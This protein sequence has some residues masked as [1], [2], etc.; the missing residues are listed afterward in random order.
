MKIIPLL[1]ICIIL[2]IALSPLNAQV[3]DN[4]YR[5]GYLRLEIM[6]EHESFLDFKK[7]VFTVENAWYN[8]ELS[9]EVFI[10]EL[11]FYSDIGKYLLSKEAITYNYPD[12]SSVLSHASLFKL[13]TDTIAIQI[14]DTTISY[15]LPFQYNHEDYSGEKDWANMFVTTLMATRKGNCHSLPLLYKLIAEEMGEKAWLAL[16]PNHLYIKLHNEANGWYNT[17]L[18]S[19]IFPT[20]AWIKSSG[21]IHLNAIKNGIYMDTLSQKETIALCM[22]D[23]ALGYQRKYPDSYDSGFVLK[24]CDKALE[25][26]PHYMNGLLLKAEMMYRIYE[27]GQEKDPKELEGIEKL[28]AHVHQLGYRK[29]PKEMYLHWLESMGRNSEK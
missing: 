8:E 22:V 27:S 21:Y 16:A 19:G 7:A 24:C 18:T 3:I 29:M 13:M 9:Y 14:N 11:K 26:F 25:Y 20:D 1:N 17:E 10:N 4:A 6:L 12:Y 2:L 15:H 28:Y 23:L 5:R